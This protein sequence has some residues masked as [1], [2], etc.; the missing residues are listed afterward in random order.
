MVIITPSSIR[1]LTRSLALRPPAYHISQANKYG[2][3]VCVCAYSKQRQSRISYRRGRGSPQN[4]V[5]NR[6]AFFFFVFVCVVLLRVGWGL[7][8][9]WTRLCQWLCV[10]FVLAGD[11]DADD[12]IACVCVCARQA[13]LR[14]SEI[15]ELFRQNK[16]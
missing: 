12:V 11:G 3:H 6:C 8:G 7:V 16:F 14:S 2:T 9:F 15:I 5:N 10:L 1:V 4:V 13:K